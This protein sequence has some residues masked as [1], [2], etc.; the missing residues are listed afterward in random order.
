MQVYMHNTK[1]P[2]NIAEIQKNPL[3]PPPNTIKIRK[4]E[5]P[6]RLERRCREE[7]FCIALY[8][9]SLKYQRFSLNLTEIEK[10][11]V[12]LRNASYFL[13]NIHALRHN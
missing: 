6:A 12:K 5:L 7:S 9:I 8:G 4:K 13:T 1:Y 2:E 10:L 3:S 11:S